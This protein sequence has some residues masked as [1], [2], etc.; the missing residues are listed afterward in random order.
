MPA[1]DGGGIENFLLNYYKNMNRDEFV[2]DV[3]VHGEKRGML[4]GIFEDMGA[5]IY[6]I[7]TKHESII[8]N[9]RAMKKI[10]KVG[11]Y[12]IV[13]AHQQVIGFIPM[14]YAKKAGVKMRI[15]HS[16]SANEEKG[17]F[18]KIVKCFLL[19]L[20]KKN[21]TN[22]FACGQDAGRALWGENAIEQ[23]QVHIMKN[24]I[25]LEKFI[26]NPLIREQKREELGIRS[27]LVIGNVGRFSV[28]KNH[29]F[30]VEIFNEIHKINDSSILLLVG[31]GELEEKVKRQVEN[32]GLRDSV[33]FLGVRN[34]VPELLQVMDVFLLPS[35]SEGLPVVLV[36]A[37]TAGLKVIASDIVTKEIKITELITYIS[38]EKSSKYWADQTIELIKNNNKIDPYQQM[39]LNGYDIKL[40]AKKMEQYYS[41]AINK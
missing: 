5:T 12:D 31:R 29:E 10:I 40:E 13:H 22:W 15:T 9:M 3:I 16:H 35:K 26:F 34:D 24:A 37:Q 4:E 19:Q 27:E 21:T 20:L 25:H 32:L 7:P 6:H 36:E 28:E 1:L 23:K 30:L 17:I 8:Q 39:Q 41:E 2:F 18:R 14:Y 33:I 38:L 11:K